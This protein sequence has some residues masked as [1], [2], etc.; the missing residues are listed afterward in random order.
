MWKTIGLA[1]WLTA[2]SVCDIRKKSVPLCLLW[3]GAVVAGVTILYQGG[4]GEVQILPMIKAVLP[5]TLLL[6]LAIGTGKAGCADGLILIV[7]GIA[8]GYQ[9]SLIICMSG[10]ALAALVSGILLLTKKAGR[11]TRI[12]FVPF[13]EAGWIIAVCGEWG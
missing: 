3:M 2:L 11:N 13:L 1:I 8:E 7:L 5:G 10:L 6:F 4:K 12:P 9:R